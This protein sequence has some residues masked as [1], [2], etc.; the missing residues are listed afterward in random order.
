MKKHPFLPLKAWSHVVAWGISLFGGVL[1]RAS[2]SV[3]AQ[4][5]ERPLAPNTRNFSPSAVANY[6]VGGKKQEIS[7]IVNS[8]SKF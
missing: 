5:F 7:A 3:I 8:R 2:A 6:L 4:T 1:S